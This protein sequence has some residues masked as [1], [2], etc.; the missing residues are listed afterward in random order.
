MIS[1]PIRKISI[2]QIQ[3]Q[4]Q[5]LEW[6]HR[7]AE[8]PPSP[9]YRKLHGQST[10]T[11]ISHS[12]QACDMVP[13]VL[14]PATSMWCLLS[15]G[16]PGAEK[17]RMR[18]LFLR[19]KPFSH[20]RHMTQTASVATCVKWSCSVT[21]IACLSSHFSSNLRHV[22]RLLFGSATWSYW[23]QLCVCGPHEPIRH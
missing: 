7:P 6:A 9:Y 1:L 18:L 17:L 4:L 3:R 22:S 19:F 10:R 13:N 14:D 23:T 2:E 16:R 12:V 21:A 5:Y 15:S 8:P 20:A 11:C